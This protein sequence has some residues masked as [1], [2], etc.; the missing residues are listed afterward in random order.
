MAE[1]V[2]LKAWACAAVNAAVRET[3]EWVDSH[4]S[5]NASASPS[6]SQEHPLVLGACSG[7]RDSLALA[8]V[9]HEALTPRGYHVGAVVV[10][11]QLQEASHSVAERTAR[12]CTHIGLSPVRIV[13][14]NVPS[15]RA[16][17]ESDARDA[18]YAALASTAKELNAAC[19]LVAHTSNDVAETILMKLLR[20]PSPEALTGI[21]RERHIHHMRFVRPL[22]EFSREDT[23][24]LCQE[25][26]LSY[27]DDPT[28]G[29]D[30]EGELDSSYPVRSRI[31][32][33]VLPLL[34]RITKRNVVQLLANSAQSSRED[35]QIIHEAVNDAY[36]RVMREK[37]GVLEIKIRALRAFP[38]A[39]QRRV[40]VTA[41]ENLDIRPTQSAIFSLLELSQIEQKKKTV[42]I[43]TPLVAN[44][45]YEVIQLWKDSDYANF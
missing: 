27:W 6:S 1:A 12:T 31:R 34:S 9:A 2:D 41:L 43:S 40:L 18:R 33:D 37:N 15:T 25:Y 16:G 44:K 42:K 36:N 7:G 24:Q 28:N 17:L 29:Q 38:A 23:T 4:K 5:Q 10:N 14:I 32:H 26:N 22:L 35:A 30:V 3:V 11:H 19:V 8:A 45:L 13:S 39:I 20:T 21:A